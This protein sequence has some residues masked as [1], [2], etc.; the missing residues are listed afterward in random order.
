MKH[1]NNTQLFQTT[2]D[3][4]TLYQSTIT[5]I[6]EEQNEI[7]T[8]SVRRMVFEERRATYTGGIIVH[9]GTYILHSPFDTLDSHTIGTILKKSIYRIYLHRTQT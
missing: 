2:D 9:V 4:C 6:S 7:D 5:N 1:Y 3:Y 8:F